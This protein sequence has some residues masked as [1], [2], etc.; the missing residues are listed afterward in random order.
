[1]S[2]VVDA[3][4]PT[5]SDFTI[6]PTTVFDNNDVNIT[7]TWTD[8]NMDMML[9]EHNA[10]GTLI[11]YTMT[12]DTSGF[13]NYTIFSTELSPGEY[14]KYR[15]LANDTLANNGTTSWKTFTVQDDTTPP[16][17][18]SK[19][20]ND[21][22]ID[23]DLNKTVLFSANITDDNSEGVSYV[24]YEITYQNGTKNNITMSGSSGWYNLSIPVNWTS[25]Y[26]VNDLTVKIYTNDSQNNWNST[27]LFDTV[28]SSKV[29]ITYGTP[30]GN[31]T[32]N[33][34]YVTD[35]GSFVD[36]W[37]TMNITLEG[38]GTANIT[39]SLSKDILGNRTDDRIAYDSSGN[40]LLSEYDEQDEPTFTWTSEY[41]N[42]TEDVIET[43]KYRVLDAC[44]DNTEKYVLEYNEFYRAKFN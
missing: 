24:V 35:S 14:I 16:H 7:L 26:G 12:N 34:F 22:E 1:M 27:E 41:I 28:H 13:S 8:P 15:S 36:I 31:E 3:S 20:T 23:L 42:E 5:Y 30:I 40:I 2:E 10:T 4:A 43:F 33:S 37:F 18:Y 38:S 11:N 21:T 29:N 6:D 17:I 39:K 32:L 44:R 25:G 19:A 9:I